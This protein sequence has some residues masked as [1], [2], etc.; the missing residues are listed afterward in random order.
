[1]TEVLTF[2]PIF[3]TVHSYTVSISLPQTQLPQGYRIPV[4]LTSKT[5]N[6]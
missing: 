2:S 1:M 3:A 4:F 5:G 6:L